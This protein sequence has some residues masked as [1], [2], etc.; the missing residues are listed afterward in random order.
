[1]QDV[2]LVGGV[3]NF[4]GALDLD[5]SDVGI[6]PRRLP[7]WTRPQLLDPSFKFSCALR[8]RARSHR[9]CG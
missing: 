1:M 7:A 8:T 4:A 6:S 2:E 3:V 9:R 5:R